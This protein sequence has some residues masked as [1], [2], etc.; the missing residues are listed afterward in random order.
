MVTVYSGHG[1]YYGKCR[2]CDYPTRSYQKV[3]YRNPKDVAIDLNQIFQLQPQIEDIVL[4]QDCYTKK[5]LIETVNEIKRFGGHIPF[6]LMLR[7]ERWISDDIGEL[8][9]DSGCTDVFIGVEALDDDILKMLNKGITVRD[10]FRSIKVL[11]KY[12]SVTIGMILFVPGI[13]KDSLINQLNNIKKLLPHLYSIEPEVL[14]VVQG[15]EYA[16]N[17]S[18]FGIKLYGSQNLLNDSWCFGLSQDIPWTM[19]DTSLMNKWFLFSEKLKKLCFNHVK[20]DYWHAI[21]ELK[22]AQ[23]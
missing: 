10:I 23:F 11:S 1:C 15:S 17:P 22:E 20:H 6:N 2:F 7:A 16:L 21:N 9:A 13:R 4:T 5:Y 3:V 8:L 19:S 18:K 12:V 14:T